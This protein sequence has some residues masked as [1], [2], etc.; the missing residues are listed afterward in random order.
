MTLTPEQGALRL[1][2]LC[3]EVHAGERVVIVSDDAS[4]PALTAALLHAA[5]AL[6][7]EGAELHVTLDDLWPAASDGRRTPALQ[8]DVLF[9]ATSTSNYHSR[10]GRVAA[11]NGA[12]V[13]A[14]TGCRAAN[15]SQ[16]AIEADFPALEARAHDVARRLSD[17]DRITITAPGG[18]ELSAQ[19]G[20]RDGVVNTGRATHPGELVGCL[21]IEA[22]IAPRE[23]SGKGTI[24]ADASTTPFGVVDE[25]IRIEVAGGRA[26]AIDGG[27]HAHALDELL[28]EH[29]PAAR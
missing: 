26:V 18:L 14:L 27:R 16:G 9:G 2:R 15:L 20:R 29:G 23:D 19:L 7:A 24:V 8:A 6:G 28:R 25:P 5:A 11:A 21:D 1:M 17:A 22:F 13:L 10:L 3:A 4:D 12:R